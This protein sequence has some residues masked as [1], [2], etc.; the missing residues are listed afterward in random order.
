MIN[1]WDTVACLHCPVK[2]LTH[3]ASLYALFCGIQATSTMTITGLKRSTLAAGREDFK[4]CLQSIRG[5][6]DAIGVKNVTDASNRLYKSLEQAFRS[7][8]FIALVSGV[9]CIALTKYAYKHAPIE[10]C[11][12][13][14]LY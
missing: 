6:I 10:P 3:Y 12:H 2:A 14:R 5:A 4:E 9:A 11:H 1:H 13:D 7:P 8:A